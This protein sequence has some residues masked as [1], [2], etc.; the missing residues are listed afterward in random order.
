MASC[1]G[2]YPSRDGH[3]KGRGCH[4]SPSTPLSLSCESAVINITA[5][6]ASLLFPVRWSTAH[7]LPH[8]FWWR[9]QPAGRSPTQI[10]TSEAAQTTDLSK[11]SGSRSGHSQQYCP[12]SQHS[13]RTPMWLQVAAQTTAFSYP[14]QTL[15]QTLGGV[16]P[17]TKTG[18]PVAA[19]ATITCLP[20]TAQT[21]Q[22]GMAPAG[23]A[24]HSQQYGPQLQHNPRALA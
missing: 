7:G 24:G 11:T 1:L 22:I 21:T 16:G 17:Q 2:C 8:G 5:K 14:P 4:G 10:R 15:R 23:R 13:P 6:A 18:P 19:Q 9:T 20:V 3:G 12:K